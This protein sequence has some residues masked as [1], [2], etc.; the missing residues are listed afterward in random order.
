MSPFQHQ[1]PSPPQGHMVPPVNWCNLRCYRCYVQW[2]KRIPKA[3]VKLRCSEY[4]DK[5]GF[6]CYKCYERPLLIFL[7]KAYARKHKRESKHFFESTSE[8][9]VCGFAPVATCAIWNVLTSTICVKMKSNEFKKNIEQTNENVFSGNDA[10]VLYNLNRKR[11]F[12][13]EDLT[14]AKGCSSSTNCC[15]A[16]GAPL[17]AIGA[18][19]VQQHSESIGLWIT[20]L[21][22]HWRSSVLRAT[23]G[24]CHPFCSL[25]QPLF[26][27][28]QKNIVRSHLSLNWFN[29]VLSWHRFFP[30]VWFHANELICC[31]S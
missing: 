7:L 9:T 30:V 11:S 21:L 15:S 14:S 1:Q 8:K 23:W 13:N 20:G 27:K 4:D 31:L 22:F 5:R 10:N 17:N 3:D 2:K 24:W 19:L 26:D 6:Y 25:L 12:I 16:G 28:D 29:A 18:P